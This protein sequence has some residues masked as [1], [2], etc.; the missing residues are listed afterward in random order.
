MTLKDGS[1]L[2]SI[3]KENMVFSEE[4]MAEKV[5]SSDALHRK[6]IA[7]AFSKNTESNFSVSQGSDEIL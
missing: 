7:F 6:E 3:G 5:A 1:S 2:L 4:T